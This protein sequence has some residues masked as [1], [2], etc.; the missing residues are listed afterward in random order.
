MASILRVTIPQVS[1]AVRSGSFE[2]KA[3]SR[4]TS[5]EIVPDESEMFDP[6]LYEA[7]R[8]PL[9][10]AE[11]PPAWVYTPRVAVSRQSR[12]AGEAG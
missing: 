11:T 8:R 9:L 7:V 12:A 10:Q 4:S 5:P 3:V 1:L 2:E 6:A